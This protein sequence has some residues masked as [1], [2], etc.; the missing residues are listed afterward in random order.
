[1]TIINIH[2]ER[3]KNI[4]KANITSGSTEYVKVQPYTDGKRKRSI[5]KRLSPFLLLELFLILLF[6]YMVVT[7]KGSME[8]P[9][10]KIILLP[11]IIANMLCADFALWNYFEGKKKGFIWVIESAVSGLIVYWLM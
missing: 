3:K 6:P 2:K 9:T 8:I 5:L 11:F 1:M 4:M 7:S 10:V